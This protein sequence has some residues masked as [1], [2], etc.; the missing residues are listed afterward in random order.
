ML[1]R[2]DRHNNP[3]AF[4]VDVAKQA[5]LVEGKDYERGDSFVVAGKTY[6]TARLLRNPIQLTVK[7]IDK[8]GF[9]TSIGKRR[10]TYI[11]IPTFLWSILNYGQK[12]FVIGE[13]Y[14]HEGGKALMSL[15]HQK[16]DV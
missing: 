2:T 4:T 13:M 7:V 10:W 15:F 11:E 8:I 6:Y 12:V 5:G 14:R 1:S 3:T 9:F 16:E